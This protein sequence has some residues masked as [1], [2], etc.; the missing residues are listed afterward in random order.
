M[1]PAKIIYYKDKWRLDLDGRAAV[2]SCI[3]TSG[4]GMELSISITSITHGVVSLNYRQS[5]RLDN[6]R[7]LN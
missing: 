5:H 1:D 7:F 6:P 2:H 4:K 3:Q